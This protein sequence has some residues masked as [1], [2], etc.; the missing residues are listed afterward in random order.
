MSRLVTEPI[1]LSIS[2]VLQIINAQKLILCPVGIKFRKQ[3][4]AVSGIQFLVFLDQLCVVNERNPL[5]ST[6][7]LQCITVFRDLSPNGNTLN[8]LIC[9]GYDGIDINLGIG[10]LFAE[11]IDFFAEGIRIFPG[12]LPESYADI[13]DPVT[14]KDI[15][16]LQLLHRFH[17]VRNGEYGV[18]LFRQDSLRGKKS[19]YIEAHHSGVSEKHIFVELIPDSVI[20]QG[21]SVQFPFFQISLSILLFL[22]HFSCLIYPVL[23]LHRRSLI[24]GVQ[25]GFSCF[26]FRHDM[27]FRCRSRLC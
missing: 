19:E 18:P 16:G 8:R 11:I 15:R 6:H 7:F 22:I 26:E 24:K 20:F 12:S 9:R 1:T 5:L 27:L 13:I 3:V 23:H 14:D 25:V 10:K 17:P 2:T 21:L 4:N